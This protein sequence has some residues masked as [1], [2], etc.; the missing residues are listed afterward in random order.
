VAAAAAAAAARGTKSAGEIDWR[1]Q[2]CTRTPIFCNVLGL[3]SVEHNHCFSLFP[4]SFVRSSTSSILHSRCSTA[5]LFGGLARC[6]WVND[7]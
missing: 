5:S 1:C 4:L 6:K 2:Y 3:A 7:V